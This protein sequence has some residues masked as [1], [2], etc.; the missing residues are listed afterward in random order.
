MGMRAYGRKVFSPKRCEMGPVRARRWAMR[1]PSGEKG[2]MTIELAAAFPVLIVV[3][4]IAVNACA[5]FHD[6]AVFDRVVGEAVRVHAASP[7]YGQTAG[8]SCSQIAQEVASQL[9]APN[10]SVSV[11]HGVVG[12]DFDEFTA[13]LEYYPTLFGLG[14][15][16]EVFGVPL[17][18]LTHVK[19]A[20]VDSYK[21]GVV[22]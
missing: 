18:H 15:R 11:S 7:P 14:M 17:P 6:C 21:A 4:V 3:A 16:S 22:V 19:S 10:L 13:T 12:A 20:V 2:Q 8:S 1:L 5:F 9:D